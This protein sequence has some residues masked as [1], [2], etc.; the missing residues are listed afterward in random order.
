MS[1]N[2]SELIST[3][4]FR[5]PMTLNKQRRKGLDCFDS[6][7]QGLCNSLNY[8]N[9]V[10]KTQTKPLLIEGSFLIE[11]SVSGMLVFLG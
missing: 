7:P 8:T 4:A 3:C 1:H 6:A 5:E 2:Q 10:F 11:L 9:T